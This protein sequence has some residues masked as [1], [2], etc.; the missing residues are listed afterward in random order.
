MQDTK[1]ETGTTADALE[2][3]RQ[4][5]A[6]IRET[7]EA[8]S[9]EIE[10]CR[11]RITSLARSGTV[12]ADEALADVEHELDAY[13]ARGRRKLDEWIAGRCRPSHS[14]EAVHMQP[15]SRPSIDRLLGVVELPNGHV[16]DPGE[17]L[18]ALLEDKI[19]DAVTSRIQ[20]AC[21]EP[22]VP[23]HDDRLA[24]IRRQSKRLEQLEREHD[25]LIDEQA[26]LFGTAPSARTQRARRE[27][28]Q[29]AHL[30]ALNAP[31]QELSTDG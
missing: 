14:A 9:N 15:R 6:R 27:A 22:T 10:S 19:R 5:H 3:V 2:A 28:E 25:A 11:Q 4:A 17:V 26:E 24:E 13:I 30:E 29:R 12:P 16:S 18:A 31:A 23:G 1:H 21:A 20:A 8:K 7:I